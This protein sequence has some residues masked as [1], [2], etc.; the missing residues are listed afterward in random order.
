MKTF[1]TKEKRSAPAVSTS[2]HY[3]H[4]PMGAAQKV[5]QVNMRKILRPD[6]VQAKPDIGEADSKYEQETDHAVAD[7]HVPAISGIPGGGPSG[8][9]LIQRSENEEPEEE[10][11]LAVGRG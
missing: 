5:Q 1:A 3:V 6:E 11:Q 4:H 7:L 9:P 8:A 2:H 10:L